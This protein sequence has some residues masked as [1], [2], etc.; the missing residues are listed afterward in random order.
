MRLAF[1]FN[2]GRSGTTGSYFGSSASWLG[3]SYDHW[4]LDAA[5]QIPA[6]YDLYVRIDHGDDYEVPLPAHLRPAMFYA[7]DTHL[8]RSWTRIR[9]LANQ[10]DLVLCCHRDA[11]GRLPSAAWLPVACDPELHHPVEVPVIWDVAFVGTDRGSP[12]KFILQAIRERYPRSFLGGVDYR[13]ISEIYSQARIGFNYAV[14]DDVNMRV[15]EVLAS[16]TLLLTNALAGDDLI[17]L[18]LMDR[19]HLVLY[20]NPKE[21]LD[22]MAYYLEH[23]QERRAIAQA[24]YELV[25]RQHTYVHRMKQL[26]WHAGTRLKVSIPTTLQESDACIFS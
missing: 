24:G 18:G 19:R 16:Q 10:F 21:L 3:I 5:Q 9:R 4:A 26:L 12:R 14:A 23:V 22:L 1:I 13:R 17:R 15:F 11:V 2:R 7:I 8:R 20:R 25:R 6:T